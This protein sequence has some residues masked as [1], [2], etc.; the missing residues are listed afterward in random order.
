M[1]KLLNTKLQ[2]PPLR[3]ERVY[4]PH[5]YEHLAGFDS[6]VVLVSAPPG[7]GKSTLVIEWLTV[8]NRPFAWYSLDRY[9]SDLG[10]FSEYLG[11]AV[12]SLTG[13]ESGLVSL[14][15]ERTPDSRAMIATLVEDLSE[16]PDNA[17]LVL[18]DYHQVESRDVHEAV[19]YL[20]ENLPRGVLL[21][22]VTRA[23]P[24][25]PVSRL[26]ARDRLYEI[27]G[28]DLR[29]TPDQVAEYFRSSANM[30]LDEEQ[31]R[32]VTE[33]S[34]GW[35]SAIQLVLLGIDHDEPSS[36]VDSLSAQ[37]P[38]IAGYLVDEVLDRLRPE[39]ASFLLDTSPFER[40]DAQLCRDAAGVADAA[41]LIGEV[42]KDRKSVV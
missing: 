33:R 18:D 30:I 11:I 13:R 14:P 9:D 31:L 10:L 28:A 12:G 15:G 16:A 2:P 23:D 32:V 21:V 42:K 20:A 36:L 37:H 41:S 35:I 34:E 24:P 5:L 26:R 38:H 22:I 19:N 8:Q 1:A 40:F 6:G 29:F 7:F 39:L 25:L 3:R 27:R 17:V 4:R